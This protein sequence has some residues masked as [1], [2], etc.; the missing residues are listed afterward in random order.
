MSFICGQCD[1]FKDKKCYRKPTEPFI[2]DTVQDACNEFK[3]PD[4]IEA[5]HEQQ[6]YID[7]SAYGVI[8]NEDQTVRLK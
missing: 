2:T 4:D 6:S 1:H 5:D 3:Y 7:F 8:K